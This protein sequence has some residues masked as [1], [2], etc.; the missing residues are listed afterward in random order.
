MQAKVVETMIA[1]EVACKPKIV[2]PSP[3]KK[4]LKY[5]TI[6]VRQT[7]HND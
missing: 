3:K 1:N 5:N 4:M 7:V 2:A 6:P